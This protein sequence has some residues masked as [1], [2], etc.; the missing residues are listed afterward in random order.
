MTGRVLL[1]GCVAMA[2]IGCAPR[3]AQEVVVYT[4]LDEEFSRPI[5]EEFTRDTGIE[6]LVVPDVEST[7]S[8]GLTQ[9]I[10]TERRRP[11]C[12]V[13]WNNEIVNTLRLEQAGLLAEYESPVAKAYDKQYRSPRGTWF[14]FAARARVLV[15]NTELVEEDERPTSIHDLTD[16]KWKDRVGIAKPLVGTTATH[17]ACLF[18]A[19][20]DEQAKEFFRAVK[21]NARIMGG[22][23]Q[24]ARAVA[25]GELAFGLTDTDD[26]IVEIESGMP[27]AIVFPDQTGDDALG[28]LLIPNTLSVIKGAPH[29]DAAEK[30]LEYLLSSDVEERLAE[31]PSAQFPL[32]RN[33]KLT[34]R[35]MPKEGI[36]RMEV[37]FQAAAKQWDAAAEF[38]KEEFATA[39]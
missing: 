30:L 14:G 8:V 21:A 27:V 28:T 1:V 19:W 24:V 16:E 33:A 20:G 5:L 2:C 4:A 6:V 3:S 31:G 11:R 17:A 18:A 15:V 9:R 10:M 36:K 25:E 34:S 22:N 37:D 38:L 26:A 32:N 12:D 7:K 13:F 29:R 35:V 39:E 23:K